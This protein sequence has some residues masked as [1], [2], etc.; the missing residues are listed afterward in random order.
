MIFS[1]NCTYRIPVKAFLMQECEACADPE[2]GGQ[3]G[4]NPSPLKRS[5]KI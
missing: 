1:N 2:G 5:Q 3:G 4:P